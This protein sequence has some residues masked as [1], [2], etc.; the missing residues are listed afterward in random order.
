MVSMVAPVIPQVSPVPF[1]AATMGAPIASIGHTG[2]VPHASSGR[3]F[4]GNVPFATWMENDLSYYEVLSFELFWNGLASFEEFSKGIF[5]VLVSETAWELES[6]SI[7]ISCPYMSVLFLNIFAIDMLIFSR[8]QT[9][10]TL[11]CPGCDRRP[12]GTALS[13]HW[14]HHWPASHANGRWKITRNGSCHLSDPC[15]TFLLGGN[16]LFFGI[17]GKGGWLSGGC[18][19]RICILVLGNVP[20]WDITYRW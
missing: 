4:F 20:V 2:H 3:I 7:Y 11:W 15:L 16:Y 5:E 9:L 12:I 17:L 19:W 18:P 13:E 1:L 14:P 8:G 10:S 6:L